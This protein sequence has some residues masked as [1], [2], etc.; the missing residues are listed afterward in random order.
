MTD[1]KNH[2]PVASTRQEKQKNDLENIL[3]TTRSRGWWALGFISVAIVLVGIWACLAKVPQSTTGTG[4]VDALVYTFDLTSPATGNVSFTGITGGNIGAG[5]PLGTI[6]TAD[7]TKVPLISKSAGQI[8]SIE[9]GQNSYVRF[10]DSL[11]TVS[12]VADPSSPIQVVMFLGASDMLHYPIGAVVNVSA[13]D[14]VSGRSV[15][16]TAKVFDEGS[17]PSSEATLNDVNGNLS[18]LTNQWMTKSSG[19]PFAVFL[20]ID[21]WPTD[22]SSFSPRGG[23]VVNVSHTYDTVHPIS[24]LF[25]GK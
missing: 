11:L 19:L 2:D 6:T 22:A 15:Y 4:V 7:G 12:T 18:A 24:W 9:I 16:T 17:T 20:Q 10:G 14:V 3:E 13:T 25:G 1:S 23:L 5:V 21:N 8:A